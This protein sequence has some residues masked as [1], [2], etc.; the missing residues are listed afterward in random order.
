MTGKIILITG[1]SGGLGSAIAK[2]LAGSGA[3]LALH[4]SGN[5][6]ELEKLASELNKATN[7]HKTFF[8][9]LRSENDIRN[10][11]TEVTG[12]FGGID[13][14]INNAGIP[15]SGMSWKQSSDQWNEIQMVNI[16]APFLV[17]KYCIPH[18]RNNTG[19]KI[20]YISSVVAHRPLP[21]TSAYAASKSAVEGLT[22]A[23]AIEL[24]R[25]GITVNCIAPG[26]F[27]AGMITSVDEKSRE[28]I[29]E[30]IP[31]KRLGKPSELAALVNYLCSGES[32]YMTGQVLHL[33]GGLYL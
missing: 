24:S 5:N 4:G 26:Y 19:S 27:D 13:I 3:K 25:F 11:I 17:S 31:L 2:S 14:L 30:D 23:Q 8:A 21:G 12:H 1:A 22:K 6:N 29:I 9:D 7:T 16:T 32:S 15:F 28:Q 10:M 20:I 18:L 33:N